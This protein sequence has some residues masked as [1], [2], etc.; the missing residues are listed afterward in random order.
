M[1]NIEEINEPVRLE[2]VT[3]ALILG[4]CAMISMPLLARLDGLFQFFYLAGLGA[5]VIAYPWFPLFAVL[6]GLL[7]FLYALLGPW[8]YLPFPVRAMAE[9]VPG[10]QWIFEAI[11]VFGYWRHVV[12][13]REIKRDH[14]KREA[15]SISY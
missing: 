8:I 9:W 1:L 3:Y 6:Y 15:H 7:P 12:L 4:A 13:Q 2:H 14:A 10:T 11:A 5:V